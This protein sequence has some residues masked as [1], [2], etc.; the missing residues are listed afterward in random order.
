LDKISQN[1]L[2]DL[3]FSGKDLDNVD[4]DLIKS[5]TF[6]F[7]KP[8]IKETVKEESLENIFDETEKQVKLKKEPLKNVPN[9]KD[10][11]SIDE[12]LQFMSRSYAEFL[13]SR[14]VNLFFDNVRRK[15]ITFYQIRCQLFTILLVY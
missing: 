10:L 15:S 11:G 7:W 9:L 6:G 8:W 4:L 1:G 14:Q 5:T 12:T 3:L 13:Y 2:S